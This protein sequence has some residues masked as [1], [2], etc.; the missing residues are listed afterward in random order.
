MKE[1]IIPVSILLKIQNY[2]YTN[3][4][5]YSP[6]EIDKLIDATVITW[7]IVY[8]MYSRYGVNEYGYFSVYSCNED[9]RKIDITIEGNRYYYSTF[10]D[11]L[12]DTLI[13]IQNPNNYSTGT[14][15][16]KSYTKSYMLN[17]EWGS[18]YNYKIN[19]LKYKQTVDKDREELIT[20]YSEHENLINT[21]H[22]VQ[23][24]I[25]KLIEYLEANLGKRMKPKTFK[26][27]WGKTMIDNTRVIDEET[28]YRCLFDALRI[29]NR[30][31]YY[32][33]RDRVY[34]SLS[35][36]SSLC[37]DFIFIDGIKM[38]EIDVV[39]CQPLLLNTLVD[40]SNLRRVCQDGKFYEVLMEATG[41]ED[42]NEIKIMTYRDLFFGTYKP[43]SVLGKAFQSLFP[44]AHKYLL[45]Y[46][47]DLDETLAKNLQMKEAEIFI[48]VAIET[49]KDFPVI[50][51]HDAL[52]IPMTYRTKMQYELTMKFGEYGIIPR[53]SS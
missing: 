6:K 28:I 13:L 40:D 42:R 16:T 44:H 22:R 4:S 49:V 10:I 9:L 24:D 36:L 50:T 27:S 5:E 14:E 47:Y 17:C 12:C 11:I 20:E 31:I 51:K 45:N 39:N 37:N 15:T 2:C 35:N 43:N 30:K 33:V 52:F 8:G 34:S 25:V 18:L 26:N 38:E 3:F 1:T 21:L 53:F 7:N 46:Q 32:T 19:Y 41:I 48:G 23:I 29:N